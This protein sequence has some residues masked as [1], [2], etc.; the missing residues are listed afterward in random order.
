MNKL[1][2]TL[3]LFLFMQSGAWAVT[4][5]NVSVAPSG[6]DYSTIQGIFTAAGT[7]NL[8]SAATGVFSHTTGITGTMSDNTAVTGLTSGA[9]GTCVHASSTQ[10]LIKSITGTFQ[11]GE[12]V[13]ETLGTN[14]VTLNSVAASPYLNIVI[15]GTWASADTVNVNTGNVTSG[16]SNTI[17]IKATGMSRNNGIFP[18]G[19][20]GYWMK[21][22]TGDAITVTGSSG[23]ITIDGLA[24][25]MTTS[26][27]N[28]IDA[29]NYA[30]NYTITNN[31]FKLSNGR[32]FINNNISGTNY[33]YNNICIGNYTQNYNECV[34]ITGGGISSG[35]SFYEY[36]NVSY[37]MGT[38][39]DTDN[40]TN[41]T[42][43]IYFYNNFSGHNFGPNG[44]IYR[45]SRAFAGSNNICDDSSSCTTSPLTSGTNNA[46]SYTSY[47]TSPSTGIFSLISGSIL[48]AGGVNESGTFT[49]DITGATRQSSGA[50]DVGAFYYA[51]SGTVNHGFT[52]FL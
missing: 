48:I 41:S 1:F 36:N 17:I 51:S 37:S 7:I 49:T 4:G 28:A 11:S 44:S 6:G 52:K 40:G 32:G 47:F 33:F 20:G 10:I 35:T 3:F 31:F 46:T 50:W 12:I 22:T 14:Y 5:F 27:G 42:V 45:P 25:D 13:Y 23:Y 15:S 24:F 38:G 34:Q 19:S 16:S 21:P 18:S 43:K 39:F 26:G 8:T 29:D 30:P 9:T 2:I